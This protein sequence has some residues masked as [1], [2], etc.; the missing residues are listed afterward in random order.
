VAHLHAL[1]TRSDEPLGET[2]NIT[3][4]GRVADKFDNELLGGSLKII[5]CRCVAGEIANELL[6]GS[7]KISLFRCSLDKIADDR[8]WLCYNYLVHTIY[9]RACR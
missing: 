2:L 5:S 9:R 4:F 8:Q 1:W 7:S 6:D 3:L